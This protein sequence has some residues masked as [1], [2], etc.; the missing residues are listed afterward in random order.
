MLKVFERFKFL[1]RQQL[2][3]ESFDAW[4]VSLRSMV[5]SCGYGASGDSVLRDQIVL[6]VLDSQTRE[7][8]LFE[9]T[10]DLSKACD[11]VRSCE[12]SR[13]QLSQLSTDLTT[14]RPDESDSWVS[15][16]SG[17]KGVAG[18]GNQQKRSG[19]SGGSGQSLVNCAG[20]GRPHVV[21]G[22][23]AA[24]IECYAGG[25]TGHYARRCPNP[26]PRQ[27]PSSQQTSATAPTHSHR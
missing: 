21:G 14:R 27:Q 1:R 15:E 5:K 13:S 19:N 23:S 3:G 2:P 18:G 17:R 20:C 10:L 12:A 25:K 4:I 22:C 26:T 24:N 9:K 16:K 11:I 6:G 7:K 8:L